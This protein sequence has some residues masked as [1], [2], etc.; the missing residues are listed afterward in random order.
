MVTRGHAPQCSRGSDQLVSGVSATLILEL[1]VAW[2]SL[3]ATVGEAA[4]TIS[5][6]VDREAG[7]AI[8]RTAW[9]T[10]PAEALVVLVPA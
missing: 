7:S 10:S 3:V 4:T 9:A 8:T 1:V 5:A 2:A 6:P